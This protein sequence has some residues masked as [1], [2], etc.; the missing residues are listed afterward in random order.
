VRDAAE[1]TLS[2]IT[3]PAMTIRPRLERGEGLKWLLAKR[4]GL[5]QQWVTCVMAI[6]QF[7]NSYGSG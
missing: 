4:S 5:H 3:T 7:I 2:V 6:Y 1:T